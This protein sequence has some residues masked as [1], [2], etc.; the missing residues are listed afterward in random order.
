MPRHIRKGDQVQVIAGADKGKVGEV[1]RVD[2]ASG[3]VIV[4][5]VAR[6]YRHLRPSRQNPQGG[7]I[8]KEMPISISNVLPVDPQTHQPTRVGFRLNEEG[9]KERY[10]KKSGASLGPVSKTPNTDK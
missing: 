1:V 8:E 4:Q 2:D 9:V 7:R 6:V 3:K 5:G 10:A